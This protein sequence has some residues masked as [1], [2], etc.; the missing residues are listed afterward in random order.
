MT[1]RADLFD[2]IKTTDYHWIA[3]RSGVPG[4]SY[5]FAAA[6]SYGRIE[7]YIDRGDREE[8]KFIYDELFKHKEE[9]DSLF[10]G[11][12]VWDRLDNRR[13]SKIQSGIDGNVFDEE[14]WD[15][16]I[17]FMTDAMVSAELAFK[18]PI[19]EVGAKLK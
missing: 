6:K 5:N 9:I 17:A 3:K 4:I 16:M 2:Q 8:N 18:K 15:K 11:D 13:A 14:Q 1:A 10:E 12:L 19:K 7:I